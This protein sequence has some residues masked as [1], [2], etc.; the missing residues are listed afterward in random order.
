LILPAIQRAPSALSRSLGKKQ[1]VV[2]RWHRC[3]PQIALVFVVLAGRHP[4]NET[5]VR[6]LA[7]VFVKSHMK[8]PPAK[9][10]GVGAKYYGYY[11]ALPAIFNMHP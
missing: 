2:R 5:L 4:Q 8:L 7:N 10:L 1:L 3:G 11:S 9:F 6:R